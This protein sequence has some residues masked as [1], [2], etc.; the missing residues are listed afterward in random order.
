M[1]PEYVCKQ[2]EDGYRSRA[3]QIEELTTELK[4]CKNELEKRDRED[5]DIS[6][7][8]EGLQKANEQK[9]QLEDRIVRGVYVC[10]CIV[11]FPPN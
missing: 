2:I 1:F 8:R 4:E 6:K 3:Q 9:K 7:L 11:P 5:D 10:V